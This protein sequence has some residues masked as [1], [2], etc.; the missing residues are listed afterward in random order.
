MLQYFHGHL[1]GTNDTICVN[2]PTKE[3]ITSLSF[4]ERKMSFDVGYA[5]C[6]KKDAYS[7]K[8]GRELSSSRLKSLTLALEQMFFEENRVFMV[9]KD[10]E[11]NFTLV[12][13]VHSNSER[14]RLINV[15][16]E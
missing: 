1:K 10:S 12:F 6:S 9:F 15:V 3:E 16:L 11:S 4:A 5:R 14:V 2:V 13:S 7:K 8:I